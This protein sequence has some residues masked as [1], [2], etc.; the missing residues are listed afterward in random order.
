M[1]VKPRAS[2][3]LVLILALAVVILP[4]QPAKADSCNV[5]TVLGDFVPDDVI[6]AHKPIVYIYLACDLGEIML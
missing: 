5:T 2:Y 1:R 3:A 6:Y 4:A